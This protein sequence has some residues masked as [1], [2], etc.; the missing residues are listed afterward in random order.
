MYETEHGAL[1]RSLFRHFF[2]CLV[3]HVFPAIGR[4][5]IELLLQTWK[6]GVKG[7]DFSTV[8]GFLCKIVNHKHVGVLVR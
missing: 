1:F 8:V 6:G 4:E 5:T 3:A 7:C 2:G